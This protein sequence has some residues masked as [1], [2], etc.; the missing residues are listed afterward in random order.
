MAG[1]NN[2]DSAVDK[3]GIIY[4]ERLSQT[5][6]RV[7]QAVKVHYIGRTKYQRV[8]VVDTPDFGKMLVLDGK[9]QFSLSDEFI[10]HECLVQPVMISHPN[11]EE[12]LIIGGGDGGALR[13]VLKHDSVKNVTLVDLD[14]EVMEIVKKYIPEMAARAFRDPRV[15]VINVDGR[16]FLQ[17][18]DRRFDVI[19]V[20]LTDPLPSNPSTALYTQE[21]YRLVE[22]ALKNGGAMSTHCEGAYFSRETFLVIYK[23]IE[24]VFKKTRVFGAFIPSFG[25]FWMFTVA[26][27]TLDPLNLSVEAIKNKIKTRNIETKFYYPELHENLFKLSKNLL[28]DLKRK[29]VNIS[30]DKSPVQRPI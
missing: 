14:A 30:T 2:L 9:V 21:F 4:H 18:T 22:K 12:I 8:E 28:E 13:E 17:E 25:D 3:G 29:E 20:D 24:S 1:E 6:S 27:N 5:L 16:G 19:I 7:F 15:K 11:P 10:Y 23:T 26:S